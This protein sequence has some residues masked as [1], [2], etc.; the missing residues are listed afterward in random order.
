VHGT[1]AQPA[2]RPDRQGVKGEPRRA[3]PVASSSI[4]HPYAGTFW[5]DQPTE[6]ELRDQDR[7]LREVH[8]DAVAKAVEFFL[9]TKVVK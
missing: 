2:S 4:P 8:N 3:L 1:K 5:S 7:A 9:G 6:A